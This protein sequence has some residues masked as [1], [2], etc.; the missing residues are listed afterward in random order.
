MNLVISALWLAL[1][2]GLTACSTSSPRVITTPIRQ[3]MTG[4]EL[5]SAFGQPLRIERQPDGSEDWFYNFGSQRRES[6]PFSESTASETERRYSYGHTTT[7]TTTMTPRPVHL[8]PAGRVV[9]AIP[10]G[11][12]ISE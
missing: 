10:A 11:H 9:G 12:V 1:A 3:G 2:V 4:A 7:T 8:S 5:V 6:G